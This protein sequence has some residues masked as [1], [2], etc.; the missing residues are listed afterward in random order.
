MQVV[1]QQD[2][3]T[4]DSD[5]QSTTPA[6]N[7]ASVNVPKRKIGYIKPTTKRLKIEKPS[8][9]VRY[10]CMS[11][12]PEIDSNKNASRCKNECCTFKTHFYCSKCNVHLCIRQ[13]RNC[14]T[15]FHSPS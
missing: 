3:N 2:E 6:I 4:I 13:N 15:Q 1:K 11:H 9:S 7:I 10:D 5:I 14:F 12:W 8:E